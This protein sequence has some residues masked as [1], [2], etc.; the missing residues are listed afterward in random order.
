VIN[1]PNDNVGELD[2]ESL[3]AKS[4]RHVERE[5]LEREAV[6]RVDGRKLRRK[7]RSATLSFKV[8]PETVEQ[9]QRL[10]LAEGTTMV[11]ILE[12]A[13]DQ[14]EANLRGRPKE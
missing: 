6:A 7:G 13:I 11:D 4:R 8:R 1:N 10:A 2:I 9:V 14:Y 5:N 3:A 12:Q